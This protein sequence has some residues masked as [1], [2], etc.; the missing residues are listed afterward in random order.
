MSRNKRKLRLKQGFNRRRRFRLKAFKEKT[1]RRFSLDKVVTGPTSD[2]VKMSDL[3]EEF[4]EP[5]EKYAETDEAYKN[6]LM[7]A[8]IA[9]NVTLFPE[10]ERASKLE[11][12]LSTL[13]RIT[14]KDGRQIIRE[15]MTRKERYFAQHKRMILDFTV[16]EGGDDC[17]LSVL[18]TANPV[19][20]G[21]D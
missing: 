1:Q 10:K 17:R 9:W 15:L 7:T 2:G 13:P 19:G 16:E 6:L 21:H 8:A 5:Y 20:V 18:S 14:R 3:L 4:V 12:L 11:E